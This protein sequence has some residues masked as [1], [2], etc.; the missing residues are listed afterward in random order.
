MGMEPEI[1]KLTQIYSKFFGNLDINYSLLGA[2]VI[3]LILMTIVDHFMNS[4]F[5]V[6]SLF[7]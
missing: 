7:K 6:M 4:K 3:T 1:A 2:G 5:K